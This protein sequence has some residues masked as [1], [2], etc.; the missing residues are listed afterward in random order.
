MF[1]GMVRVVLVAAIVGEA[2]AAVVADAVLTPPDK[3]L[4]LGVPSILR[5]VAFVLAFLASLLVYEEY[6]E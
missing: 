5:L 6:R 2:A 4:V 3:T 1:G